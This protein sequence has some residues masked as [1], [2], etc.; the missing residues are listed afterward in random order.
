[1]KI[2]I[3]GSLGNIGKPLAQKLIASGNQVTVVSSSSDRVEA[4]EALGAKAA[5]GSVSDADFLK[6]TFAETDAVFALTPP[7]MGGSNIIA[8]TTD[9]GKAI[10]TA[11]AATGVKRVVM[12]S[13]IGADLPGGTGPITGLYN[14]E[15]I[16]ET[17][18]N[19]SVTFLRAGFFYNNL[20]ANVPMIKGAGIIGSN[21]AGETVM[22]FV[23]P[24]NIATAAAA[25]LVKTSRGKNIR[26]IISDIRTPNDVA[27]VLGLAIDKPELP[28]VEFTDEQ[29]LGGMKEA[30]LPEEIAE[31]YTEMGSG[32]RSGKIQEDFLKNKV[33]VDGTTKL[34]DFAKEFAANF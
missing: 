17:L 19:V 18:D 6:K 21:Y 2:T 31:L 13:S 11:I 25:E 20:Y 33:S 32:L 10:A 15:K 26:Y 14:I 16:Y 5:I 12:L 8:N 22:P 27:K 1:M 23:H 4:I 28:W 7:N 30:G 3:L 29:S 9:A 24:E 34:E